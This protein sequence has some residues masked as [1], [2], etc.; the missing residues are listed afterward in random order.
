M[1][2]KNNEQNLIPFGQRT[3]EE[4]RAIQSKGGTSSGKARRR[5][6]DMMK[7]MQWLLNMPASGNADKFLESLGIDENDRTNQVA[8]LSAIAMKAMS[9]DVRAAEF[10]RDTAGYNPRQ[11]LEERRFEAEQEITQGGSGVV[12]DWIDA[13]PDAPPPDGEEADN[14][15]DDQSPGPEKET[16]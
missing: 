7:A 11:R 2:H 5:K 14:G 12:S 10:V 13:I 8:I 9:G 1:A 6:R 15:S 3:V 16:P 4:E